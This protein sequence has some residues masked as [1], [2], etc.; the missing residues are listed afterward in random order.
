VGS[1]AGSLIAAILST[2]QRSEIKNFSN[3]DLCYD[4]KVVGWNGQ[5]FFDIFKNA[6]IKKPLGSI[7]TLKNFI[8]LQT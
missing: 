7:D 1:S 6:I 8:R 2:L 5:G 3:Y 4:R